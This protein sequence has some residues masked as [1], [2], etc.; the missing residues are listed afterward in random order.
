M[1]LVIYDLV[2]AN[3]KLQNKNKR[4]IFSIKTSWLTNT[5]IKIVLGIFFIFTIQCRYTVY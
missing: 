3:F 2:M 5:S 1:A 4:D